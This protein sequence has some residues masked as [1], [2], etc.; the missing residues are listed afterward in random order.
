RRDDRLGLGGGDRWRQLGVVLR[1]GHVGVIRLVVVG[2]RQLGK[3][4]LLKS[5]LRHRTGKWPLDRDRRLA[6]G[7]RGVLGAGCL[8]GA[9]TAASTAGRDQTH[10]RRGGQERSSLHQFSLL[11][12][13]CSE[14]PPSYAGVPSG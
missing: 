7:L 11:L 12:W 3:V 2:D 13:S 10:E 4:Q 14:L 9:A 8:R 5:D 6:R 1:Q